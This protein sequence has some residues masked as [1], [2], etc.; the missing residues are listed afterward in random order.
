MSEYWAGL[1]E[2]NQVALL[3]SF[4][5]ALST[6]VVAVAA[7]LIGFLLNNAAN[8]R[9]ARYTSDLAKEQMRSVGF[10]KIAEFR[11]SWIED[12]RHKIADLYAFQYDLY[13]LLRDRNRYIPS[14]FSQKRREL[15][16]LIAK[17]RQ[18]I[19]LRINP[20]T[21]HE[22]EIRL[23]ELLRKSVSAD[24]QEALKLRKDISLAANQVLNAEWK[25][26]K[27]ELQL[28]DKED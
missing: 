20:S 4:A 14:E 15:W 12:L 24:K 25:K 17:T 16:V 5:G 28:N 1:T 9:Q 11:V 19:L 10:Q 21:E 7:A 13:L 8:K 26:L 6:L 27:R 23:R 3:S 2:D 22:S 18:D